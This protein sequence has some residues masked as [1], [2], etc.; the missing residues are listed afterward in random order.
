MGVAFCGEKIKM[1]SVVLR[2]S[3]RTSKDAENVILKLK[4]SNIPE[5]NTVAFMFAC[6]GRGHSYYNG[7][8]NVE[9]DAFHKVFPKTPL[10]G[11]FGNGEVGFD[12][13]PDY[14]AADVEETYSVL[15]QYPS[16]EGYVW[17]LPEIHHSYTTI[18]V[19]MSLGS[20]T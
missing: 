9:A 18:F 12:Y 3:V 11:F 6:I 2:S 20:R 5:D 8:G 1:A 14:S 17:D 10:F 19:L 4:R 15:S 16:E 7:Q 13:L